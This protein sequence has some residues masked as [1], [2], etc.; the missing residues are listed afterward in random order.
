MSE[1]SYY[2]SPVMAWLT[3]ALTAGLGLLWLI[4]RLGRD[5]NQITGRP[6]VDV[7]FHTTTILLFFVAHAVLTLTIIASVGRHAVDLNMDSAEGLK[8]AAYVIGTASLI[9]L[10]IGLRAVHEGLQRALHEPSGILD[11]LFIV[12]MTFAFFASVPYLQ[13]RLNVLASATSSREAPG[14]QPC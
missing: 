1:P 10:V 9:S 12:A 14:A 5:L 2:R 8:A 11:R 3:V 6:L 4:P 7:G 13:N